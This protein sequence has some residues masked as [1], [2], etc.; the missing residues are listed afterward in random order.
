M[1]LDPSRT[2]FVF[3]GQGSQTV[4]MGR[5]LSESES[6]A[7]AVFQQAD[8]ILGLP[9]SRI[10]FEGPASE[11][12]QTHITQP[13]LFTHSTAVLHVL[14]KR[15][16][17]LSPACAAGHSLGQ[18]SALVAAGS[19]SFADGLRLVRARGLA[20]KRAGER[21]RGGMA[22]V[23]G[24][25]VEAVEAACRQASESTGAVVQVANDNCPGQ[26]VI[27]GAEAGLAAAVPLLE[28]AGARKVV[29]LAVSIAAHSALM[30]AAQE[31]FQRA[32]DAADLFAP[33]LP[34]WGNV[35]AAP[36]R[37]REQI[38]ADLAAQL[39]SRVRWTE[40]IRGLVTA[41]IT[42]FIE[43]GPGDVLTGLLRRIERS[44]TGIPVGDP[45]GLARLAG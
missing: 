11:L 15:F 8:Q 41:G 40:T 19:L 31:E 6:E 38:Q 27:S 22:A 1:T 42:H 28:Q 25:E 33:R 36:L 44:A 9:L 29:R 39:T 7:A 5:A 10:C 20:M 4:G 3:P 16:P 2:A 30:Q 18:F 45:P 13:A 21:S 17:E 35:S 43:L 12:D 26:V 14:Q 32:L 23:L 24:L 34:V 37:T